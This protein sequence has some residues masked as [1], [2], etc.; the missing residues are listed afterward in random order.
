MHALL[1]IFE[2]LPY[3]LLGCYGN[4]NATTPG[5]DRC[6][7][8]CTTFDLCFTT[9]PGVC[10]TLPGLLGTITQFAVPGGPPSVQSCKKAAS[11]H[12]S[13]RRPWARQ[14]AR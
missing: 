14:T 11:R 7:S 9:A 3:G 13:L 5:F 2:R 6:A 8:R 4:M 1:I 12:L 10:G